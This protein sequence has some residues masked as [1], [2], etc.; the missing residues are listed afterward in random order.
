MKRLPL[1]LAAVAA[2]SLAGSAFAGAGEDIIA[3]EKCNKCHTEKT[4]KKGPS[5]ASLAEKYKGKA[6]AP[7]KLLKELKDGGKVG[8]EDD[9]KKVAASEAD[10]K[11]VVAVVLSSK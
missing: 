11:A 10:L 3:K 8:D 9:H 5:F 1:I 2:I 6:D 7:A 4:T